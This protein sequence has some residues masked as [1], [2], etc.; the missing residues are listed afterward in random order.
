MAPTPMYPNPVFSQVLFPIIRPR[1]HPVDHDRML[2]DTI[3][4]LHHDR[5]PFDIHWDTA[6]VR[7]TDDTLVSLM[8]C[9]VSEGIFPSEKIKGPIGQ[10][11]HFF[12]P[13]LT[14]SLYL[15]SITFTCVDHAFRQEDKE[16][17]PNVVYPMGELETPYQLFFA[18]GAVDPPVREETSVPLLQPPKKICWYSVRDAVVPGIYTMSARFILINLCRLPRLDSAGLRDLYAHANTSILSV[19][20]TN[21]PDLA[22][23]IN[24]YLHE[25]CYQRL[26]LRGTGGKATTMGVTMGPLKNGRDYSSEEEEL[27]N[28][29]V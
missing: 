3:D 2:K 7:T 26:K 1:T 29:Y 21:F 10:F 23:A 12:K 22:S 8:K 14:N 6:L 11:I 16:D 24:A 20:S 25:G 17:S 28:A 9:L 13:S 4:F 27:E 19:S 18:P 5:D 15:A